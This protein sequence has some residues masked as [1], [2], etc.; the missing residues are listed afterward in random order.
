MTTTT[1]TCDHGYET[2]RRTKR[3]ESI[4]P[5]CRRLEK[6]KTERAAVVTATVL[7]P[8]FDHAMLAAHDDTDDEPRVIDLT[9]R[10]RSRTTPH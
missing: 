3:G 10:R 2:L 1:P 9:V 6:R 5:W 4:C 7:Q 8:T